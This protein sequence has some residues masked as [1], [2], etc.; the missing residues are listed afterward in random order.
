MSP[1]RTDV[2]RI[3]IVGSGPIVIGQACE[4]D[5][6]GTQACEVLRREGFHVSL[7]ELW[8]EAP[9]MLQQPFVVDGGSFVIEKLAFAAPA[10]PGCA[11]PSNA[12]RAWS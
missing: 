4:F 1:R 11:S 6:S 3:L 9:G 8:L 2:H 10:R 7:D 12:P 5:Y